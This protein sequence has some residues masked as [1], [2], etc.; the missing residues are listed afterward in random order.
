MT[1]ENIG[2]SNTLALLCVTDSTA[3]CRYSVRGDWFF[4]NGTPVPNTI[5]D[6]QGLMWDFYRNRNT[7]PGL[8]RMIRRR[9][10]V[11]GIYH[12]VI[13]DTAGVDQTIY[14]GVYTAT[15]GE[16]YMCTEICHGNFGPAKILV[17]GTKIPE[18]FGP[19]DYSEN[20]GPCVE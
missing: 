17:R 7:N 11:D 16:W 4:P 1:L 14:I 3:C 20:I 13:P 19:P 2:D 6:A 5:I 9:G 12:C 10:G 18:K 15:T 8:V